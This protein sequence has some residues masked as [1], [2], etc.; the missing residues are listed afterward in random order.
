MAARI[1]VPLVRL[2]PLSPRHSIVHPPH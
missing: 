1:V 2:L